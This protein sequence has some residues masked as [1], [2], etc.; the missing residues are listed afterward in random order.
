MTT[1]VEL[2]HDTW[3]PLDHRPPPEYIPPIWIGPHVGYRLIEGLRVLMRMPPVRGPQAFGNSWPTHGYDWADLL[4]QQEA[5]EEEKRQNQSAQN[6]VWILPSS[7]EISR[8]E[9]AIGWPA[10]YLLELSQL[11]R[12]VQV[13][14]LVRARH[15][16]LRRAARR[17]ELPE[18]LTRRW[19]HDGLDA[20]A[21]GLRRDNVPVF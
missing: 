16:D 9:A 18:R 12:T 4:A 5:D 1:T 14:A 3:H 11:L 10:H 19:N 8:M 15:G 21:A 7:I 17:L 6:R 2:L 20:I 13:V